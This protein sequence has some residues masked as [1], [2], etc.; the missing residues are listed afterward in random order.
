MPTTLATFL[1]AITSSVAARVM[2][3]LGLGFISYAS[4][5]TL[6]S[7]VVSSVTSSYQSL[8][9]VPLALVNLCGFGTA[10]GILTSALVVRA[11]LLSIKHIGIK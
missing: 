11:S 4:L 7:S 6:A 9:A 3:S 10:L 1:L 8:G 5:S 2:T